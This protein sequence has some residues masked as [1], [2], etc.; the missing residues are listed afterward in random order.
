MLLLPATL[1]SSAS[2]C[3]GGAGARPALL[4]LLLSPASVREFLC[5]RRAEGEAAM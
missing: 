4:A 2:P 1:P 5:R 3:L